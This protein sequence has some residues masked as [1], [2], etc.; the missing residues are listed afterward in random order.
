M[1][2]FEQQDRARSRTGLLVVLFVLA[3]VFVISGVYAA[4]MGV[5]LYNSSDPGV[6]FYNPELFLV[7]AGLTLLV[8]FVGSIIK[9]RALSRGGSYVAEGLGGRLVDSSTTD[10]DQR[11]LLNVVEEMAIASG[12]PVPPVYLLEDEEGINAF[13][14]GFSPNDAVIGVTRGVAGGSAGMNCRGSSPT[15]SAIS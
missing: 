5:V 8:I 1:D 3:V 9:I 15:S 11:Q 10:P 6:S 13:A 12:V 14:A 7:I 2:F 4:I